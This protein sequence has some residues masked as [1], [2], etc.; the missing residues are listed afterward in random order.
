MT[1]TATNM[2]TAE[3]GSEMTAADFGSEMTAAR[4]CVDL[5][6]LGV[7]FR[8]QSCTVL[9]W[10]GSIMDQLQY[11]D[12]G[13]DWLQYGDDG[14]PSKRE[15]G[16]DN[17]STIMNLQ[18]CYP[19]NPR[20]K[21]DVSSLGSLHTSHT[22]YSFVGISRSHLRESTHLNTNQER[23]RKHWKAGQH[24]TIQSTHMH[25]RTFTLDHE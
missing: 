21:V 13:M 1:T 3:F 8:E 7:Q 22:N 2:E 4:I 18:D 17:F 5:Q 15:K 14:Q 16:S 6:Y 23:E 24:G 10:K 25:I 20:P 19:P 11:G 9:F 12:D